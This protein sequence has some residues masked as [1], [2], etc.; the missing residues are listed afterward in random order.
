MNNK[1]PNCNSEI[2]EGIF[3]SNKLIPNEST[4]LIN[5]VN[6]TNIINFCEKCSYVLLGPALHKLNAMIVN[7]KQSIIKLLPI[8][9]VTSLGM[10]LG[11]DYKVIDIVT[12]QSVSGTGVFSEISM[13]VSDMF[14]AES[15]TMNNK[16][17]DAENNC[18]LRLRQSAIEKGGNAIIGVDLDYSEVGSLRGMIMVC[19]TGTIVKVTNTDVFSKEVVSSISKIDSMS[20]ELKKLISCKKSYISH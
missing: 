20:N 16:I 7:I 17:R 12:S 15:D 9:P 19:A 10:P 18:F 8:V 3:G 1:C 13:S 4:I 2:K 5:T 14:G 6:N 11:W